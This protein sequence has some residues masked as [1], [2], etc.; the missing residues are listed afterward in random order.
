M[1]TDV[2]PRIHE[3]GLP[4]IDAYACAH[5]EKVYCDDWSARE[6]E[7]RGSPVSVDAVKC[8]E[9]HALVDLD[10]GVCE[11]GWDIDAAEDENGERLPINVCPEC[12]CD[13]VRDYIGVS[14]MNDY[15]GCPKC[16]AIIGPPINEHCDRPTIKIPPPPDGGE[17]TKG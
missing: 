10:D 13:D 6:C 16:F 17:A 7:C 1:R 14:K 2:A 5:C 9:C 15:C 8:P 11:C 4:I 3:C 12:G